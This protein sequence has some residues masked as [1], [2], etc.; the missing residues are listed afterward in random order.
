[1][2]YWVNLGLDVPVDHIEIYPRQDGCC[3]DRLANFQ[4]SLHADNNGELGDLSWSADLFTDAGSNAG[5][6]PGTVVI[7]RP[8][9]GFGE[10]HGSWIRILAL[11]DPVPQY[12]LQLTE[13]EVYGVSRPRLSFVARP[14]GLELTWNEGGLETAPNLDGP[15]QA[16]LNIT[17]PA[18]ISTATGKRYFRLRR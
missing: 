9:D 6:A 12:F 8:E 18:L 13:L 2:A 7:L 1:M 10:F 17:S 15:W 16:A 3:P 5:A 14:T 11:G 4:V